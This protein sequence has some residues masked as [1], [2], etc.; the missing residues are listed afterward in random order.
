MATVAAQSPED[1]VNLALVRIGYKTRIGSLYEGS[2]AS[3]A[4]LSI[5]AQ[6]RD[7]MLRSF[8]WSFAQRTMP[9]TEIK[10]APAGGYVPPTVW[11]TDF[12]PVPWRYEI[13]YPADCLKVRAVKNVPLLLPDFDPQPY[14][15]AIDNDNSL[16]EPSKVILCNVFPGVIVYTAQVTNPQDWEADFTEALAASLGRHLAPILVGLQPAQMAAQDEA[17]AVAVAENT[18]G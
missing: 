4:A 6:T 10:T 3:K 1:V 15:F 9:M 7:E 2:N 13:Q 12:P 17:Q 18:R 5:Y 16:A 8:D 14:Q 11:S